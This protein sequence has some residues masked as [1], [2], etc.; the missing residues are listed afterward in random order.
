MA[1]QTNNPILCLNFNKIMIKVLHKDKWVYQQIHQVKILI[2]VKVNHFGLVTWKHGWVNRILPLN[3]IILRLWQASNLLE[4]N[5]RGIL[6]GMALSNLQIIRQLE[7]YLTLWMAKEF[8]DTKIGFL[9]SIG[10]LMEVELQESSLWVQ[11]TTSLYKGKLSLNK[12]FLNH[13]LVL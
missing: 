1:T 4:I 8:P 9:N 10:H 3:L 6:L 11:Q 5:K 2:Q 7:M 12:L 13:L